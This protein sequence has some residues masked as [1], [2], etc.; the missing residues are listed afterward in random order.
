MLPPTIASLCHMMEFTN[1]V[2]SRIE[3]G[4]E[5]DCVYMYFSKAFDRINHEILLVKMTLR[6]FPVMF[7]SSIASYLIGRNQSVIVRDANSSAINNT[8]VVPQGSILGPLL[9]IS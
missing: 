9:F 6:K 5:V 1:Y 8:T 2:M 4:S 7:I 3:G